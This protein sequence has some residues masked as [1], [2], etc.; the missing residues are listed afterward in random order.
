MQNKVSRVIIDTNLW[1]SFLI[2]KDFTRLDSLLISRK[3]VLIFSEELLNEF[4]EVTKRPKFKKFFL[5]NHIK[6]VLD[7]IDE[8]GDFVTVDSVATACRDK[9]DNFLLALAKDGA[10]DFLITSDND[11]LE[12]KEFEGTKIL[13]FRDFLNR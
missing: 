12:L 13:S 6:I 8:Y 1:I 10:A 9:K 2:T 5:K 7:T 11:L 4:L 3:V